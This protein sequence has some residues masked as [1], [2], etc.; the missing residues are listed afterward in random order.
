MS[1][2]LSK[3]ERKAF[4]ALAGRLMSARIGGDCDTALICLGE[5]QRIR[6][7]NALQNIRLAR[8]SKEAIK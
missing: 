5:M 4:S 3:S 6:D 2:T 7:I 1:K 8:A